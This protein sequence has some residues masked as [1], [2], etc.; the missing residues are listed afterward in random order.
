VSSSIAYKLVPEFM[1]KAAIV[2]TRMVLL[3]FWYPG[4]KKFVIVN[5]LF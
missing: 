4:Q 1:L 3:Y 5:I 2:S